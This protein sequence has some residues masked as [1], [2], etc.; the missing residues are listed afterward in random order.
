MIENEGEEDMKILISGVVEEA[1]R[2]R[3]LNNP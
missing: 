1:T 3:K 2:L